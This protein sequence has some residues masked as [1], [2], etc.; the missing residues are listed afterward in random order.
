MLE[1]MTNIYIKFK[2]DTL[3]EKINSGG[4]NTDNSKMCENDFTS[5]ERREMYKSA[6]FRSPIQM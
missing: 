3:N 5:A 4:R 2:P 6:M 1:Q